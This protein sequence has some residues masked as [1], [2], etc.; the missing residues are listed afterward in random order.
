MQGGSNSAT[1]DLGLTGGGAG[2]LLPVVNAPALTE[3]P[4]LQ[5][6][7]SGSGRRIKIESST[8]PGREGTSG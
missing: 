7:S 4:L 6:S 3:D 1:W 2:L 8:Q 5:T